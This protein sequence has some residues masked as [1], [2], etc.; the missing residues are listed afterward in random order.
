MGASSRPEFNIKDPEKVDEYLIDWLEKW[1]VQMGDLKD[2]VLAGHSFGGYISG[3]YAIKYPENIKKLLMLSPLGVSRMP[4]GFDLI[5][6]IEKFPADQRP[7]TFFIKS[8]ITM[9]PY[10]W[11]VMKSPFELMRSTG[12]YMSNMIL[13]YYIKKRF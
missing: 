6:E 11:S 12:P 13:D 10:L 5:K 4:E 7:P 3:L 2:F 1:R 8:V 9:W